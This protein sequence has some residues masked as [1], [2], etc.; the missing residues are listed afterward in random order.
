[1]WTSL[2]N[3]RRTGLLM[4]GL[5]VAVAALGCG[6]RGGSHQTNEFKIALVVAGKVT[7]KSWCQAGYEGLKRVESEVGAEVAFSEQVAPQDRVQAMSDYAR[8]GYRVVI[9]HGGEF[10]D[11][12]LQAGERNNDTLFLVNAGTRTA[13]NVG[14]VNFHSKQPGYLVGYVAAKSSKT[15]KIGFIGGTKVKLLEELLEGYRS[16]AMAAKPTIS[17]VES[18]TNDWDDLVKGREAALAQIN[19]GVDVILPTLDNAN[20]GCLQAAKEKGIKAIGIYYDAIADWPEIVIQSAIIDIRGAMVETLKQVKAGATA[21]KEYRYGLDTP[22]AVRLGTFHATVP[23]PVRDE[24]EQ[25]AKLI[26]NGQLS[27]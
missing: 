7:D 2:L 26:R 6:H 18:W 25:L 4:V 17:V 11:S 5:I 19:D 15:G 21:G 13:R 1:M 23:Q 12:A 16:G 10:Q 9:G 3:M 24:V 20:L 22:A 8:R 14:T 27:P